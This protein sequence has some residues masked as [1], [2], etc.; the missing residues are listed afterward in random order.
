MDVAYTSSSISET[1][2]NRFC[3][4]FTSLREAT[5]RLESYCT[6]CWVILF[7]SQPLLVTDAA[8]VRDVSSVM[9]L[10]LF[11][12]VPSFICPSSPSTR[13]RRSASKIEK[14]PVSSAKNSVMS[15]KLRPFVSGRKLY[16]MTKVKRHPAASI[17]KKMGHEIVSWMVKNVPTI[18][19]ATA[20]FSKVAM[21][22]P[23]ALIL[24]ANIS[25]GNSQPTGPKPIPYDARNN[26]RPKIAM[27][28]LADEFTA[29]DPLLF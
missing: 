26:V 18:M 7:S 25:E 17:M 13:S 29:K 3:A 5:V 16:K 27:V 6:A 15:S 9:R 11:V 4:Y 10:R 2:P 23:P 28:E 1:G 19:V 8:K 22:T 12:S 20:L 14:S 24:V 21:L